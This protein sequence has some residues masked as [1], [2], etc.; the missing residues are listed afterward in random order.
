MTERRRG[1]RIHNKTR[2]TGNAVHL[3]K[4]QGH[5]LSSTR[6][7]Q[8]PGGSMAASLPPT[9]DSMEHTLPYLISITGVSWI[10][11]ARTRRLKTAQADRA[12]QRRCQH[13]GLQAE[14]CRLITELLLARRIHYEA[15]I[16]FDIQ[17]WFSGL[18]KGGQQLA[19]LIGMALLVD[20]QIE[21]GDQRRDLLQVI[22]QRYGQPQGV[23][24][25]G[26]KAVVIELIG[27]IESKTTILQIAIDVIRIDA[28][29]PLV[30]SQLQAGAHQFADFA[31]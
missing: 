9:V 24:L 19:L 13:L 20:R 15:L 16:I 7:R 5:S 23:G 3:R 28:I 14:L 10:I 22:F 8:I 4:K 18:H 21:A 31:G 25:P 27:G 12:I 26:E 17:D 2:D 11:C 29:T 6:K 1:N 30:A